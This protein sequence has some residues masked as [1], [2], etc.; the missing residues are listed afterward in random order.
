MTVTLVG[1]AVCLVLACAVAVFALIA[2]RIRTLSG[3]VGSFECAARPA[4]PADGPWVAGI[5]QYGA[6]RLDWWRSWSLAPRPSRSWRRAQ[7][8]V[9]GRVSLAGAGRGDLY[10]V[11]CRHLDDDFELT[12]SPEAYAG[13]ASWLEAAPPSTVIRI[14]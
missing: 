14:I 10:L 12:M 6:G 9:V 4:Q 3:R 1:V 5:A 2:S 7:F 8:E 13:L 11:R